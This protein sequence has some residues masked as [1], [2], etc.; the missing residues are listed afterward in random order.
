MNKDV[1]N[2]I[3]SICV[4]VSLFACSHT[5]EQSKQ[6]VELQAKITLGNKIAT[7]AQS[8]LGAPYRYGGASPQGFDCS[9][10]VYYTHKQFGVTTPRTSQAQF[11]LA[12]PVQLNRLASGDVIFFKLNRQKISHVGIYVGIGRFIHAP[13]SGKKVAMNYLNDPYW[14]SRIISGGRLY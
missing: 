13:T 14:K 11:G 9:G 5:L 12:K 2:I 1:S 8:Q 10:L 7:L 4:V 6:N 3:L